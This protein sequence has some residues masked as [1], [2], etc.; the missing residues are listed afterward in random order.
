VAPAAGVPPLSEFKLAEVSLKTMWDEL[1]AAQ[2][3]AQ[4]AG[5]P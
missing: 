1:E 3:A 4:A 2:Q 5:L